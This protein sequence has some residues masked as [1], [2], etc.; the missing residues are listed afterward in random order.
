MNLK[1]MLSGNTEQLLTA[2]DYR[3]ASQLRV[4]AGKMLLFT[5]PLVTL[6]AVTNW[7]GLMIPAFYIPAAILIPPINFFLMKT[8]PQNGKKPLG[9]TLKKLLFSPFLGIVAVIFGGGIYEALFARSTQYQMQ[10]WSE[11]T[12]G[13]FQ[14]AHGWTLIVAGL[15]MTGVCAWLSYT[16]M[17]GKRTQ[18]MQRIAAHLAAQEAENA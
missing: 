1:K 12:A 15:V 18:S 2:K 16:L 11:S 6:G 8:V 4:H 7:P 5:T 13:H 10:R 17:R 14:A 3:I 9:S